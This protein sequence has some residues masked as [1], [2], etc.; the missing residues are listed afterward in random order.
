MGIGEA[1]HAVMGRRRHRSLQNGDD[2]LDPPHRVVIQSGSVNP[3]LRPDPADHRHGL[4]HAVMDQDDARHHEG[5]LRKI[6]TGPRVGK[7]LHEPHHIV[8][9]K[10]DGAATEFGQAINLGGGESLD[11]GPDRL[12]GLVCNRSS[13]LFPP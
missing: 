5:R 8:A 1:A 11:Q 4:P 9:E 10:T 7:F 13:S 12:Q 3:F 2:V 6:E